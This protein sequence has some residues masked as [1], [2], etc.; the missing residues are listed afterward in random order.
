MKQFALVFLLASVPISFIP[1][2]AAQAQTQIQFKPITTPQLIPLMKGE[3]I[4]YGTNFGDVPLERAILQAVQNG[5]LKVKM[6]TDSDLVNNMRPLKAAG[7][8][9]YSIDADFTN[10]I[11]VLNNGAI[12][13]TK[14]SGQHQIV[15]DPQLTASMRAALDVYWRYAKPY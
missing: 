1:A 14:R 12:V 3:I 6:L 5:S 9:V 2:Q 7:A 11:M 13:T 4:L 8:S 10:G 15:T